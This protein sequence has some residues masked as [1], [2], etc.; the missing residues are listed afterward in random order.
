MGVALR[1][2]PRGQI[3]WGQVVLGQREA[4][5]NNEKQRQT[6]RNV[7]SV[8]GGGILNIRGA[9]VKSSRRTRPAGTRCPSCRFRRRDETANRRHPPPCPAT[10]SS[11]LPATDPRQRRPRARRGT[12]RRF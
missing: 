2:G 10:G 3:L 12:R 8:A 9:P 1:G 11:R 5:T 4:T 6:T 7:A